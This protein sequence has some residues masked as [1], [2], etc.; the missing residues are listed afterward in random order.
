M[1]RP[2]DFDRDF[3]LYISISTHSV[4]GVLIQ[5]DDN[6]TEHVIYY[7]SKNLAGPS[8]SYSHEENLA[9][10]VVFSVQK[11]HHYILM[12]STKVVT[13]SNPMAFLLSR[14]ILSGKYTRWVVILQE[15]NLE[16]VTPKINKGLALAKLISELPTGTQDP[17]INDAL[18]DE[19]LFAITT[20]RKS[21]V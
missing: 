2:L 20:D 7:V 1:I 8:V 13:N 21:V 6:G 5:E 17:P 9:L 12:H 4:A 10:D 15:F 16:F 18:P 19:H 14:H 3:I 11:L